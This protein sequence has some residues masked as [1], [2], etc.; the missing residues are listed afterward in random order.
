[1][2]VCPAKSAGSR[3]AFV[4]CE[5]FMV[6]VLSADQEAVARHFARPSPDKFATG[7]MVP[8][9]LDL[10]GLPGAT[11]RLA[12]ALHDVLD[13]GD[14]SI[15]VGRAQAVYSG[16]QQPL[17]YHNRAFTRP[18]PSPALAGAR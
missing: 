5:R 10:P 6:N 11:A 2:L 8:C 14:H 12:C 9:E 3:Q 13:G 15:L 16:E 18:E 4:T 7:D 1:V 17:I